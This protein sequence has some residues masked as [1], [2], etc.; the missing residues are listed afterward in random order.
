MFYK[1]VMLIKPVLLDGCFIDFQLSTN[2]KIFI[3]SYL[4]LK[5][6]K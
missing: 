6:F 2:Q 3:F 1:S 5:K 4:F